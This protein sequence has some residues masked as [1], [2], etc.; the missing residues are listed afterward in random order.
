M[1]IHSKDLEQTIEVYNATGQNQSETARQLN[2]AR[3]TLQHRLQLAAQRGLLGPTDGRVSPGF[4]I[5]GKTTLYRPSRSG[6]DEGEVVLEWVRTQAER[7]SLDDILS[8][9]K[10]AFSTLPARVDFPVAPALVSSDLVTVYIVADLHLG[11]YAW[12]EET[13]HNYD[14]MIAERLLTESMEELVAGS[15]PS[16]TA[17]ILNLGDFFHSDSDENRTRRSGNALDVDTRYAKVLKSGVTLKVRL[18]EMALQK[19]Q[20]VIVRDLKGNHDPYAALALS[21]ATDAYFHKEPRVLVDT[22]PSPFWFYKWGKVMLG[23]THGDMAKAVDM[24]QIMA[25]KEPK[26]WGDTI[27]R[28][29]YSGHL[30]NK[31]KLPPKEGKGAEVEVFQT[32]APRDAWGDSMGYG[33]GRSMVSITHHKEYGE[34]MRLTVNVPQE[35]R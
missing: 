19:H 24:P 20:E 30:H 10:D 5:T 12:D 22:S 32:L 28:Y 17:I 27:Y 7:K 9:I 35:K 11:M 18:T 4:L 1:T 16:H 31:Q 26:M 6:D 2:I 14:L 21:I 29:S 33:A 13:G 23:A 15:P 8:Y 34:K 25:S 3:S